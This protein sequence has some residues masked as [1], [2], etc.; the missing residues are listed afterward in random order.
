VAQS[1]LIN[2]SYKELINLLKY[3]RHFGSPTVIGGWA[4]YFYN[5]YYGSVDIDIV[6]AS[7]QGHF[8][9]V[10]DNYVRDYKYTIMK[11][12]DFGLQ[13]TAH[14][15]VF[16]GD[17]RVGAV[18]IDAATFE[19]KEAIKFHED[20]SKVLPYF[21]CADN[22]LR[23]EL[24]IEKDCFCYIPS[25]TLLLLY[26]IKAW[27]DRAFDVRTKGATMLT[28]RLAWMQAKVAKDQ[29]DI[30]AILDPSPSKKVVDGTIDTKMLNKICKDYDIYSLVRQ[31]LEELR[32]SNEALKFYN[33]NIRLETLE[34]WIKPLQ[35]AL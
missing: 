19:E 24:T 7:M 31:S 15:D 32:Y 18:E 9:S 29:S 14:K 4:V 23:T 20:R 12:D 33:P 26:K 13:T 17:E 6:G 25:K 35:N 22:K 28:E 21:L 8:N 5:S 30:I 2:E 3:F 1:D 16:H 27:R 34:S 10:L 11:L